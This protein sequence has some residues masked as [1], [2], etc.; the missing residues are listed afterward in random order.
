[1]HLL[2]ASHDEVLV[3]LVEIEEFLN[4]SFGKSTNVFGWVKSTVPIPTIP[5]P[6]VFR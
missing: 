2:S 5:R 4:E 6:T 3:V 1:M